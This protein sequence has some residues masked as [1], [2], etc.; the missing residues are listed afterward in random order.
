MVQGVARPA[1]CEPL[2]AA[3]DAGLQAYRAGDYVAALRWF[4][5]AGETKADETLQFNLALT[6]YQLGDYAKAREGFETLRGSAALGA[7]AEYHL[8]LVAARQGML[9]LAAEHLGQARAMSGSGD[10]Q[11]LVDVALERL[12]QTTNPRRARFSLAGGA[13]V[14]SNRTQSSERERA[15][16]A[17][18]EAVFGQIAATAGYA[19]ASV[20]D[21][22]VS[23]GVYLRD[24]AGDAR[25]DQQA[26][27]LGVRRAGSASGWQLG[28]GGEAASVLLDDALFQYVLGGSADALHRLGEGSLVLSYRPRRIFGGSDYEYVDGWSQ[29]A[30]ASY[31]RNASGLRARFSAE[32]DLEDRRDLRRGEEFFSQSPLRL[33]LGATLSRALAPRLR[34]EGS[35][36]YRYSRYRDEHRFVSGPSLVEQRRVDRQL[37]LVTAAPLALGSSCTARLEYRY[38]HNPSTVERYDYERHFVLLNLEWSPRP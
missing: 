38:S 1:K 15:D 10:M 5:E 35:A 33:G 7:A 3:F 16:G 4:R 37:Q 11:R 25:Y 29:R 31:I 2:P 30:E 26:L 27:Q 21:T 28:F 23:G 19:L 8:G 6:L 13:G 36:H 22:Q 12:Q 9:T 24:D 17:D 20:A 18:P 14:D 34:L 32:I